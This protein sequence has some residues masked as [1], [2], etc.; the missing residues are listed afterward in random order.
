MK[1]RRHNLVHKIIVILF[2]LNTSFVTGC[3][4]STNEIN[5]TE[6]NP[7][8]TNYLSYS[9]TVHQN[10]QL[11]PDI[12]EKISPAVV[13]VAT[14]SIVGDGMQD[15]LKIEE[16]IGSGFIINEEGYVLTNYHVISGAD[17]VKVI[18]SN[19]TEANAGIVNYD[20]SQDLAVIK[21]TDN[22]EITAVAPLGDSDAL[23]VGETVI[24][25]GN[26]LGKEFIGTVTSGIVSAVNR[27]IMIDNRKLSFIQ[28]DAAI[29]PGN[30]GGPLINTQGEVIGINTAK[31][32]ASGIEGIGFSIPINIVKGR[33]TALS[34]PLPYLGMMAMKVTEEMRRYEAIPTGVF[35]N[36]VEKDGCS[37]VAGLRC[38][39]VIVEFDGQKVTDVKEIEAIKAK[40]KKGDKIQV[41]FYRNGYRQVRT[42]TL[43]Q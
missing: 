6:I 22:V 24:A 29:N 20:E 2:I 13:G 34:T 39:D 7:V 43:T 16:G 37:C 27:G 17:T 26:P 23:S 1:I 15:G 5:N 14:R 33:L 19:N 35:V 30:S 31:I 41:V 8:K 9:D 38:G 36:G 10:N 21:I 11:I 42:M 32:G 12:V 40:H 25:I 28:T 4:S 18:F 3:E